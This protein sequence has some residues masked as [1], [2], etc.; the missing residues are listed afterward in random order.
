MGKVTD[1]K[2]GFLL[3]LILVLGL[4]LRAWLA[5]LVFPNQGFAWDL[6]TFGNWLDSIS[7]RGL[8]AY[9]YDQTINYPPVFADILVVLTWLGEALGVHPI[10]LIKAPSILADLGIA[11]LLA[12]GGR[13]WFSARTGLVAAFAFCFVPVAWYDS[14]IWGQV[15]SLAALPMLAAIF[16][17]IEKKPEWAI[18]LFVIAVLTKPQG[19]LAIFVILP[20]LIGQ[21]IGGEITRKRLGTSAAAGMLTFTVIAV[22]WSLEAF[23]PRGVADIPVVGDLVG[24]AGQYISTAGLFPVLS[25]NA[26]NVWAVFGEIPL[27]QQFQD[28]RV[29]WLTD[30]FT[31]LGIPAGLIGGFMFLAIAAFAFWFLVRNH[32]AKHVLTA[33]A[34]L[35]VAFFAVPTRVHER[36]LVQAFTILALVW[37]V[38]I[39]KQISLWVLS[40]ANTINLH[41]ILAADLRVETVQ[42]ESDPLAWGVSNWAPRQSIEVLSGQ[43]PE[44]YGISWVRLDAEWAR[45]P[46]IVYLVIALHTAA[47]VLVALQYWKLN[48]G[49][50]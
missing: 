17:L 32:D 31:I 13:K 24:L 12:Y 3:G 30:N 8:D 19:A 36:Y 29:F 47:L 15:D 41:A 25:A 40:L 44:V 2:F 37:S 38:S 27:A 23:A 21:V 6:A 50:K 11:A 42:M 49:K 16:F 10:S 4:V 28:G 39:W 33:Y 9:D 46:G 1:R 45:S 35:L 20:V 18:V 14:A 34:L 48:Q 43:P 7:S 5:F 26:Y 22:P